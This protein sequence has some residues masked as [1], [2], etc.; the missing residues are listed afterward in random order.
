MLVSLTREICIPEA[1]WVMYRKVGRSWH[2]VKFAAAGGAVFR[3]GPTRFAE[4]I[5]DP[6]PT[7][8]LCTARRWLSR[9]WHW[10]GRRLVH[11]TY[12]R[13]RRPTFP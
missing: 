6:R 5:P 12:H 4:E 9:T 3:H 10:N 2:R 1:G 13:V 7:E 11:G 8:T